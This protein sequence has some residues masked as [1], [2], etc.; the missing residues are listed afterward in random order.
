MSSAHRL[1]ER[2]FVADP[3]LH[4]K[5]SNTLSNLH[6]AEVRTAHAAAAY[7]KATASQGNARANR[8]MIL[9]RSPRR[10]LGIPSLCPEVLAQ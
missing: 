7:A 6:R 5:F 8:L 4:S 2:G 9:R 3:L 10:L 1:F